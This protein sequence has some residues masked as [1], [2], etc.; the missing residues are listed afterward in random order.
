[1]I[2]ANLLKDWQTYISSAG[3]CPLSAT[4]GPES[5][6]GQEPAAW[7]PWVPWGDRDPLAESEWRGGGGPELS[8][9]Q[10]WGAVFSVG[11]PA[12][13]L[14]G[15]CSLEGV[16]AAEGPGALGPCVYPEGSWMAKGS[17][18]LLWDT[19]AGQ[20]APWPP[21]RTWL[22][23]PACG[24]SGLCPWSP[25][26]PDK[27]HCAEMTVGE[28]VPREPL[29]HMGPRWGGRKMGGSGSTRAGSVPEGMGL[30]RVQGRRADPSCSP[31]AELRALHKDTTPGAQG[32]CGQHRGG[33]W[34]AACTVPGWMSR[35]RLQGQ[36][37]SHVDS[38]SP[39]CP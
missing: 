21:G 11:S 9:A 13:S 7:A 22:P 35:P 15:Q 37:L 28:G 10:A 6:G 29:K 14:P 4:A 38:G 24:H 19:A 23:L 31:W 25:W 1:M 34:A 3:C 2:L 32:L 12:M 30:F 36:C 16:P 26:H 27:L 18:V 39:P 33:L 17:F 20:E 8:Q 5:G